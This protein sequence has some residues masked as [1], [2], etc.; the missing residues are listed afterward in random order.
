MLEACSLLSPC[1]LHFSTHCP[2][3]GLQILES[4]FY[5]PETLDSQALVVCVAFTFITNKAP[6][7]ARGRNCSLKLDN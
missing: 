7:I 1:S 5:S 4:R 3:F 6:A 2:K